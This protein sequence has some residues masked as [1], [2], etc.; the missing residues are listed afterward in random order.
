[1]FEK[2]LFGGRISNFTKNGD[3]IRPASAFRAFE[4]FEKNVRVVF[5]NNLT[6]IFLLPK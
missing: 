1:M 3:E 6:K 2:H 4:G 5:H